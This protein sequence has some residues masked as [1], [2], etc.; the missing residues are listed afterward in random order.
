MTLFFSLSARPYSH[1]PC[2]RGRTEILAT[3]FFAEELFVS[4]I[5]FKSYTWQR[6]SPQF[7][8]TQFP[9]SYSALSP[10]RLSLVQ[11][12]R[13]GPWERGCVYSRIEHKT[14][15]Q[16]CYK[17]G[18]SIIQFSRKLLLG[19]DRT[20]ITATQRQK[21]VVCVCVCLQKI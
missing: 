18:Q 12:S 5:S 10:E 13:R 4:L 1:R 9:G 2:A 3:Y 8:A 21:R 19:N 20:R 7:A 16:S 15:M 11:E 17:S 6:K 14:V